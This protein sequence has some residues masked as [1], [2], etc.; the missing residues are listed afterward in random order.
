MSKINWTKTFLGKH[1]RC[2]DF[3]PCEGHR[4]RYVE[5]KCIEVNEAEGLMVVS[6]EVDTLF[7][8]GGRESIKTPLPEE[9]LCGDYEGRIQVVRPAGTIQ[10]E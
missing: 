4:D 6:V 10:K 1:V 7:V 2:Y 8:K 9:M 5:G 3:E